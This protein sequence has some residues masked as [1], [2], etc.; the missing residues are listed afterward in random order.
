MDLL[1]NKYGII[2]I[3]KMNSIFYYFPN[4]STTVGFL[5]SIPSCEESPQIGVSMPYTN[6]FNQNRVRRE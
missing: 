5:I 3:I 6:D 4:L 2:I 1:I